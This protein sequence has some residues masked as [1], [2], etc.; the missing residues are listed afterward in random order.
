MIKSRLSG[1]GFVTV[2]G[3][4]DVEIFK[5]VEVDNLV[6]ECFIVVMSY[7]GLELISEKIVVEY[8][9]FCKFFKDEGGIFGN[10]L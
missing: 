5:W 3:K 8:D 2:L 7:I 6:F 1:V 10:I 4:V 9:C